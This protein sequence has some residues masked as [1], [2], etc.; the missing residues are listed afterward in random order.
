MTVAMG[1]M[2][3]DKPDWLTRADAKARTLDNL[4][5]GKPAEVYVSFENGVPT[6]LTCEQLSAAL[7]EGNFPELLQRSLLDAMQL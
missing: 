5:S 3:D 2:N 7:R 6:V 4:T 1:G